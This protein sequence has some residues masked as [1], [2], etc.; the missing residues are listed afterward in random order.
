MNTSNCCDTCFSQICRKEDCSCHTEK[1]TTHESNYYDVNCPKCGNRNTVIP[2]HECKPNHEIEGEKE[3]H[4]IVARPTGR[5]SSQLM[6]FYNRGTRNGA[7]ESVIF[8]TPAGNFLSPKAVENLLIHRKESIIADLEEMK[9]EISLK[10]CGD[11]CV[12]KALTEAIE[13]I[14]KGA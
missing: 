6:E 10:Y 14:R 5:V 7:S 4:R 1:A 12:D 3:F 13:V 8:A 2:P 11:E 9:V